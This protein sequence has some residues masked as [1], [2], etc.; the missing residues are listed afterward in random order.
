LRFIE[1]IDT[2]SNKLNALLE[3]IAFVFFV[4]M[5]LIVWAQIF[6]RYVLG[7]GIIWAE[8]ISKYLMVWMALLAAAIVYH[9]KGHISMQFFANRISAQRLLA[10]FQ[11]L[12]GSALFLALIIFGFEY[13][14]F[15]KRFISPASGLRRYW[16][17]LAIPVGG[18]FLFFYSVVHFLKLLFPLDKK[19]NSPIP[20]DIE[21]P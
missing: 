1:I 15:G 16:P 19:R 3:K 18:I 12:A 7:D 9:D 21:H 2:I 13:A 8:E 14:E 17:Y 20:P 4:V 5:T 10:G 11:I 6:Y